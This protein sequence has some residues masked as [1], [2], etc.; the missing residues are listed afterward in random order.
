MW[1]TYS[2]IIGGSGY[3]IEYLITGI[4]P[5]SFYFNVGGLIALP[6][7]IY[8]CYLAFKYPAK[9]TALD[10]DLKQFKKTY[11]QVFQG[12]CPNC[13]TKL[14]WDMGDK[15]PHCLSKL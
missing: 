1:F 14:G 8:A 10:I 7:F 6:F 4:V 12:R 13:R 2:F 9:D 15:C 5:N 3:I 11:Y